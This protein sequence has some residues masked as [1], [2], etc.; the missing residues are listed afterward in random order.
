MDGPQELQ[1][2]VTVPG[3]SGSAVP[4]PRA[5]AGSRSRESTRSQKGVPQE[6]KSP[7]RKEAE[8][9]TVLASITGPGCC[10]EP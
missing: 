10:G 8:K 4:G 5:A 6:S 9:G 7:R 1:D 2:T 3:S